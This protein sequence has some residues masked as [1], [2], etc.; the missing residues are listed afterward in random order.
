[1]CQAHQLAEPRFPFPY[2]GFFSRGYPLFFTVSISLEKVLTHVSL[3]PVPIQTSDTPLC[4][5][6]TWVEVFAAL[7]ALKSRG[8]RSGP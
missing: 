1:M 8:Y 6:V 7:L 3:A 4:G 5:L 2:S